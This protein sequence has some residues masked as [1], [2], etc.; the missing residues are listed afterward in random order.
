M[1]SPPDRS[2]GS[3]DPLRYSPAEERN[4]DHTGRPDTTLWLF[5]ADGPA[6]RICDLAEENIGPSATLP[7]GEGSTVE[8]VRVRNPAA[9]HILAP[10]ILELEVMREAPRRARR[11]GR[12]AFAIAVAVVVIG[13]LFIFKTLPTGWTNGT[14]GHSPQAGST[15]PRLIEQTQAAVEPRAQGTKEQPTLPPARLV[16]LRAPPVSADEVIPLGLS[17][18]G[19]RGDA[20]LVLH[21]VHEPDTVAMTGAFDTVCQSLFPARVS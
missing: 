19:A 6:P 5:D 11:P 14:G 10:D 12:F 15:E 1:N 8:W 4:G 21:G 9:P 20:A 16:V 7:L 17:L 18:A 2:G 13:S 3:H